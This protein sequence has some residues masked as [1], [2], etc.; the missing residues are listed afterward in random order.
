MPKVSILYPSAMPDSMYGH[1][2]PMRFTGRI[3]DTVQGQDVDAHLNPLVIKVDEQLKSLKVFAV[4]ADT[5]TLVEPLSASGDSIAYNTQALSSPK[6]DGEGDDDKYPDTDYVPSSANRAGTEIE[7]VVLAT[8]MV[9][10]TTQMPLPGVVTHDA[11]RPVITD[12]FPTNTLIKPDNQINDATPPIF[13]LKEDVDSIA[14]TYA[15]SSGD[16]T[17]SS[18]GATKGEHSFKTQFVGQ[19]KDDVPYTMT[20]FVRDLA[21]NVFI[22]DPEL[23]KNMTFNAQFANP[24]A[25]RYKITTETDSVIAGQA[26]ILTIQAEDHDAGTNTTRNALTYKNAARI[27]AVDAS[28]NVVASVSFDGAGVTDN[29]GG[30]AMLSLADWS[31]GKR[32]VE[33]KSNMATGSFKVAVEHLNSGQ[34]GTDVVAFSSDTDVYVGA[35]D[36]AGFD[37]TAWENGVATTEI[38]GDYTLRVVPVDRHGNASVRAFK[39]APKTAKDSLNVLDTRVGGDPGAFEY[40]NGIDV[41]IVGVPTIEDFALLTLTIPKEGAEYDLVAPDNRRGQTV[42]VRGR[43]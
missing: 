15:S 17:R 27:K 26:N 43:E 35:A 5:L 8:D 10:N 23:S 39:S 4:G 38:L 24:V 25:T 1:A 41:E 21:G 13:T 37:I 34:G 22:T 30:M 40:K 14:I 36:F 20:I 3:E 9:G 28:G 7:L 32:T 42:Q 2:H 29:A 31:I 18:G 6:K 11:S 19:L 33:V 16:V 12:W